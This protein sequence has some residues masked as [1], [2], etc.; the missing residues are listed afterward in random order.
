LILQQ[1]LVTWLFNETQTNA[2]KK[3]LKPWSIFTAE[4]LEVES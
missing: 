3:L 2:E 1:E 4:M